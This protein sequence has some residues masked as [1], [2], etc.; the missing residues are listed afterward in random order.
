MLTIALA[1]T[2]VSFVVNGNGSGRETK[3]NAKDNR[4]MS[5]DETRRENDA[6][7]GTISYLRALNN[8]WFD[9]NSL[10]IACPGV[11]GEE[12]CQTQ[13]SLTLW[14]CVDLCRAWDALFASCLSCLCLPCPPCITNPCFV[15]I[16][17]F[18]S[19]SILDCVF[20]CRPEPFI[21]WMRPKSSTKY[22]FDMHYIQ[23]YKKRGKPTFSHSAL[24]DGHNCLKLISFL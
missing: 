14:P 7:T 11:H 18:T 5:R 22:N 15:V 8:T 12:Y 21:P 3:N 2:D 24:K 19:T 4:E 1:V 23:G 9:C 10:T 17:I 6:G 13:S 16:V 20:F